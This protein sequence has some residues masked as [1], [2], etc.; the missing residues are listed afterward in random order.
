MKRSN[1]Q[2]LLN[3][4]LFGALALSSGCASLAL[5]DDS[6]NV[7]VVGIEALPRE[8]LEAR[9]ALK[10]RVQNPNESALSYDGLSVNLDIAGRGLA[11]G[12]SNET[13]EIPRFSETVLTVPVSISAFSVFRQVLALADNT[14]NVSDNLNE[15]RPGSSMINGTQRNPYSGFA[16]SLGYQVTIPRRW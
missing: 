7:R 5:N 2:R 10:L 13:G 3:F 16:G 6:P 15:R 8:G 14:A 12:V 9:F 11:S 4:L 1:L